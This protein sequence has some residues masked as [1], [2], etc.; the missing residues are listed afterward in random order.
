MSLNEDEEQLITRFNR[1]IEDFAKQLDITL[2][3]FR[4]S[5]EARLTVVEKKVEILEAVV[6]P[7]SLRW[8]H[9]VGIILIPLVIALI[10]AYWR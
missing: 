8:Y 6:K 4:T 9:V 3:E 7:K 2:N 1:I 10:I 5:I